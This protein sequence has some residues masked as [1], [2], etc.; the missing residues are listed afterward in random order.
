MKTNT[1]FLLICC[2]INI[3]CTSQ[4]NTEEQ[5]NN[6]VINKKYSQIEKV[7]LR[8]QT[9]GTNRLITFTKE[10]NIMY[11][12]GTIQNLKF[13]QRIGKVFPNK[14]DLLDL[15][16]ISPTIFN[17]KKIS[18][19]AMASVIMI[20]ANGKTFSSTGFDAGIPQKNWR[21]L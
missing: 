1:L 12:N 9:R 10:S 8:E 13:L 16:K 19:G 11:L 5:K 15:S 14:A 21:T 3:K 7:E 6:S 2:I 4:H 18:D 17:N 20:T